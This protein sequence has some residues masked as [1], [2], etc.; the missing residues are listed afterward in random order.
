MI[1]NETTSV[2][3]CD[4]DYQFIL[5]GHICVHCDDFKTNEQNDAMA[6][7][8]LVER[9]TGNNAGNKPGQDVHLN[10]V[11]RFRK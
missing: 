11:E 4:H 5:I 2:I 3:T 9:Y 6:I 10:D 8:W 1:K 7:G